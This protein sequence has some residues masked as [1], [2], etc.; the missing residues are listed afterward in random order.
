MLLKALI[1]EIQSFSTHDGP[2][3]RT[4][5]FLMGCPLR[6]KWCANPEALE[7]KRQLYYIARK[8]RGCGRCEAACPQRAI[9]SRCSYPTRIDR[10]ACD[11]CMQCVDTCLYNAFGAVGTE[12][13]ADE[14]FAL[15]EREK[16]FYGKN[17]GLTFSG[18][19]ALSQG[20]FVLEIFKRC[21]EAGISTVLDTSGYGDTELLERILR[22]TDMVLLDL[23]VMDEEAHRKWTG[24]SNRLILENAAVIAAAVETRIS[25]P[26]IA[27]VNDSCENLD[28]TAEFAAGL[29]IRR[30]D[31][32][33]LHFLGTSKYRFL[34]RHS[35]YG[36]FRM[37]EK[38]EIEAVRDHLLRCGLQ[39]GIGRMM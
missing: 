4:T 36:R 18:G 13:G 5:A 1:S 22:Y 11:L 35:P 7:E 31:I 39:V 26:L 29:G 33:P 17:G 34:G 20:E 15:L 16:P 38:V 9:S 6:C 21:R 32:E 10:K 3:I 27:G 23:K 19:E 2:G 30:V 12:Y 24:V 28:A 14:F 25:L 37:M 8:C